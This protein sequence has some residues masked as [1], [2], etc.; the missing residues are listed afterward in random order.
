MDGW[1]RVGVLLID[2]GYPRREYYHPQRSMGTLMCH[3]RHRAHDDPLILTGLQDITA[4]VDF[5][6]LAEAGRALGLRV[7]GFSTQA[8]FLLS[9]G[10]DDMLRESDPNDPGSHLQLTQ[11]AKRLLLPSEMGEQFKVLA[12]CRG[13]DGPLLGFRQRDMRHRL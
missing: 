10:I 13:L 2:Y 7:A 11:Q 9:C 4:Q 1:E 5:S 6:A 3:Y 12:L 8:N